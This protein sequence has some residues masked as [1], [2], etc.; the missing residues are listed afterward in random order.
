MILKM[1]KNRL[2]NPFVYWLGV[3]ASNA[4]CYQCRD[5]QLPITL[6]QC[7]G[8]LNMTDPLPK[9]V[10][11][12]VVGHSNTVLTTVRRKTNKNFQEV[13]ACPIVGLERK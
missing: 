10:R 11:R 9:G 4:I 13:E 6:K 2:L 8:Y 1:W 3:V 12:R 7:V 5:K